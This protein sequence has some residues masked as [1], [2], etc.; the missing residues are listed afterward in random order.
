MSCFRSS[1]GSGRFVSQTTQKKAVGSFFTVHMPQLTGTTNSHRQ[2]SKGQENKMRHPSKFPSAPS[3]CVCCCALR[4]CVC[5]FLGVVSFLCEFSALCQGRPPVGPG[6][7]LPG[8]SFK[9]AG[10]VHP[11]LPCVSPRRAFGASGCAGDRGRCKNRTQRKRGRG[12]RRSNG[13]A[14]KEQGGR[15]AV[16]RGGRGQ[17]KR[18]APGVLRRGRTKAGPRRTPVA[19]HSASLSPSSLSVSPVGAAAAANDIF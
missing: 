15:A 3:V 19:F 1:C 10:G 9:F 16:R 14:R 13:S 7:L 4:R 11:P 12:K 8:A 17:R 2:N 6:A 5:C 18:E